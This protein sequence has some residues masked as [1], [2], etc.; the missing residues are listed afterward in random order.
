MIIPSSLSIGI[1]YPGSNLQPFTYHPGESLE[2]GYYASGGGDIEVAIYLGGGELVKY[3][4]FPK[5]I[6]TSGDMTPF[7][8]RFDFPNTPSKRPKPG[9]YDLNVQVYQI[10]S[11][12]GG[13]I[14]T[15]AGAQ[16]PL[17]IRVLD[18]DKYL[19][20]NSLIVEPKN[21]KLGESIKFSLNAINWGVKTIKRARGDISL[22][23]GGMPIGTLET[24]NKE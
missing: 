12:G 10:N 20:L 24:D 15:L 11:N 1:A 13:Q 23:Y 19:E 2:I 4:T 22:F 7:K 8:I 9:L 21:S 14:A 3:A 17:Y 18:P 5:T 16:V 6:K